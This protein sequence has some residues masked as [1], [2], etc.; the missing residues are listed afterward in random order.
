MGCCTSC[1]GE[2]AIFQ[3]ILHLDFDFNT[4]KGRVLPCKVRERVAQEVMFV[5][6]LPDGFEAANQIFASFE[7]FPQWELPFWGSPH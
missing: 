6:F 3:A 1:Q 5:H 7:C 4:C 2:L